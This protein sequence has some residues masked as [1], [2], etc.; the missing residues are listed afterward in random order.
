MNILWL[1]VLIVLAFFGRPGGYI[2]HGY[3]YWPTGGLGL[4]VLI[5]IILLPVG[6]I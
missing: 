4:I 1:V 3:G 2:N 6:M 5:L